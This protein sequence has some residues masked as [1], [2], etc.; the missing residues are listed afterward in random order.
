M[1][2]LVTP[3]FGRLI[4]LYVYHHHVAL[5][6]RISLTLSYHSSLS[7]IATGR[8]SRLFLLLAQS[9]CISVV[10]C[11]PAFS[12]PCEGVLC[13]ISLISS[14]LLLQQCPAYLVC[15]AWIVFVIGG[16]WPYNCCF[17]GGCLQD[18]FNTARSIFV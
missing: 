16:K 5:P 9:S 11:R 6:A 7:S 12:R 10:A 3:D 14:S 13:S 1:S 18:L 8:S 17:V 4:Y 2:L 15:L